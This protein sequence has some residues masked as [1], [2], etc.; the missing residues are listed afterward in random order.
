MQCRRLHLW[1][2]KLP[3]RREWQSIP[4]FSPGTS[5]GQRSLEGC[6]PWCRKRV[7]QDCVT[8]TFF[9]LS[10]LVNV[11]ICLFPPCQPCCLLPP[12]ECMVRDTGGC[13]LHFT[14][15]PGFRTIQ[16]Y[17]TI[18]KCFIEWINRLSLVLTLKLTLISVTTLAFSSALWDVRSGMCVF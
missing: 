18:D 10:Y 14:A 3:W 6:S 17:Q 13:F 5:H 15:S 12:L 2:R 11:F 8:N 7:R 16:Q 1:V 9:Q 4:V